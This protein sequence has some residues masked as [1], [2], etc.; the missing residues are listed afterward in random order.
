MSEIPAVARAGTTYA[1]TN[2]PYGAWANFCERGLQ[3]HLDGQVRSNLLWT[4]SNAL[5]RS[6]QLEAAERSAQ[7]KSKLDRHEG[8][9]RGAALAQGMLADIYQARGLLD[10]ALRIRQQDC[11][12]VYEKL[13]D[14]RSLLVCRAKIAIFLRTRNRSGDWAESSRLLI[15]A[16]TAALAMGLPEAEIIEKLLNQQAP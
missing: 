5:R 9:D 6:G 13:G 2:G 3:S 16:H 11:L 14:I 10:E 12:P 8:R 1:I 4:L 7:E 15:I